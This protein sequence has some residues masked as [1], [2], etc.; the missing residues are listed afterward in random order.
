MSDPLIT[1]AK[2]HDLAK[3]DVSHATLAAIH[4]LAFCALQ[5][6]GDALAM[7]STELRETLADQLSRIEDIVAP[8]LKLNSKLSGPVKR[9]GNE[10]VWGPIQLSEGD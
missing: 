5:E 6:A 1:L 7:Q 3:G 4:S 10:V 2:I 9:Q 8:P